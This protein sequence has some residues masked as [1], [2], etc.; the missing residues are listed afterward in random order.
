MTSR[1]IASDAV[2]SAEIGRDAVRSQ[3]I[4]ADAVRSWV[5]Q[6]KLTAFGDVA[7][8]QCGLVTGDTTTVDLVRPVQ[9]E[10]TY[11]V[12]R[13]SL[14]AVVTLDEPATVALRC[15]KVGPPAATPKTTVTQSAAVGED[16]SGTR[17]SC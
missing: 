8:N 16:P 2:R 4:R 11:R 7:D 14:A 12:A 10:I 9:A 3:E 13:F 6:A 5:V 15:S 17:G 1:E